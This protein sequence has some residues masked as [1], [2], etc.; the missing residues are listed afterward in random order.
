V[1]RVPGGPGLAPRNGDAAPGEMLVDEPRGLQH[2]LPAHR[3]GNPVH[4]RP[5][6]ATRA[7]RTLRPARGAQQA[8]PHARL[9][10][11]AARTF[12]SWKH[13]RMSAR[14]EQSRRV[15]FEHAA[16]EHARPTPID[17]VGAGAKEERA[18]H[19]GPEEVEPRSPGEGWQTEPTQHVDE[20][21]HVVVCLVGRREQ[22]RAPSHAI[23]EHD[24]R[25]F[26]RD[27]CGEQVRETPRVRAV[28]RTRAS[29]ISAISSPS[30]T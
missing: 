19:R 18:E 30:A 5:R 7:H 14:L 16:V 15:V 25:T 4:R 22:D 26:D 9:D 21:R 23:P 20:E 29:L 2:V 13:D 24:H 10:R 8:E 3:H 6:M 28:A 1:R 17:G 12:A 11:S 27:A